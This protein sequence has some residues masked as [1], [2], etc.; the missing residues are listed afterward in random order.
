MMKWAVKE[1]LFRALQEV[2]NIQRAEQKVY[3]NIMH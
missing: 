2:W 1:M 3:E